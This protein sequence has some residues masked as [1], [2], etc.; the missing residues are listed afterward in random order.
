[1]SRARGHC[2]HAVARQPSGRAPRPGVRGVR[3]SALASLTRAGL[4]HLLEHDRRASHRRSAGGAAIPLPS[5][6]VLERGAACARGAGAVHRRSPRA[7][8]SAPTT[9]RFARSCTRSSTTDAARC[10]AASE[11]ACARAPQTCSSAADIVVPVPLHRSRRRRR[12][13]NQ[14]RGARRGVWACRWSSALRRIRA[15]PSQTDLPAA[16]RHAQH[17]QRV[18]AARAGDLSR[19]A[20]CARGRCEHHGCDA[21]G[22][23][24]G[25]AS[26]GRA[27]MSAR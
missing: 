20:D 5:W 8:P 21:R 14:A 17:A 7:A 18:C 24:A 1:M 12:G 11:R 10:R 3:S 13:F 19:A 4:Q 22:V 23:R 25:A 6:R 16:A 26:R 15:T 27:R 9:G 2:A